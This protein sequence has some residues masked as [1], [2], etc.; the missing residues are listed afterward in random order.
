MNEQLMDYL[1]SQVPQATWAPKAPGVWYRP[2]QATSSS[3]PP[4]AGFTIGTSPP[5]GARAP[6]PTPPRSFMGA[7]PKY[8]IPTKPN[9]IREPDPKFNIGKTIPKTTQEK[10]DERQRKRTAETIKKNIETQATAP[11]KIIE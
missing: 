5:P 6:M 11:R 4:K 2:G 8:P 3:T 9:L 7:V 1:E 10:A